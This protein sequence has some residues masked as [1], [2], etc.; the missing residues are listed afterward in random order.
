MASLLRARAEQQPLPDGYMRCP[1]EPRHHVP[2]AN[3]VTHV[4]TVHAGDDI[5]I[6]P[7]AMYSVDTARRRNQYI[8]EDLYGCYVN[9]EEG[10]SASQE[11]STA[12]SS[13]TSSSCS[14]DKIYDPAQETKLCMPWAGGMGVGRRRMREE[15][16]GEGYP[17]RGSY[18]GLQAAPCWNGPHYGPPIPPLSDGT[19]CAVSLPVLD[20]GLCGDR[21]DRQHSAAAVFTVD[22]SPVLPEPP[23]PSQLVE[24]SWQARCIA[25]TRREGSSSVVAQPQALKV[26]WQHLYPHVVTCCGSQDVLRDVHIWGRRA[27]AVFT[28]ATSK[29]R[30]LDALKHDAELLQKYTL[31]DERTGE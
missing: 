23:S 3:L 19:M 8:H 31:A 10:S 5:S 17:E 20:D 29:L 14:L 13:R 6:L 24:M 2:I 22:T 12:S 1:L 15:G 4:E 16:D 26:L 30:V 21:D 28:D 7:E 25:I 27:I 18:G 9:S 11:R